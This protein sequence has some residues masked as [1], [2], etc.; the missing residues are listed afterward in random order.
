MNKWEECQ[1]PWKVFPV[2]QL[3]WLRQG[4][5]G[6]RIAEAEQETGGHIH[7]IGSKDKAVIIR[8]FDMQ[9]SLMVATW[10]EHPLQGEW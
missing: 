8:M 2:G 9:K 1:Y 7:H 5:F 4:W 3:W 6:S 10:S